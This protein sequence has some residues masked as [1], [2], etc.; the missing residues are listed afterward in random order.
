MKNKTS[1]KKGTIYA[2]LASFVFFSCSFSP[3]ATAATGRNTEEIKPTV[4]EVFVPGAAALIGKKKIKIALLLDTSNSMDG[5]IEQAKS[6]LWKIVNELALAKCENEKPE[7]EIA[8]YEYGNDRLPSSEGYIRQVSMFTNDLD[9]ISEKLFSLTTKGGSEFCGH[10]IQT[11]TQQL[12]WQGDGQNLQ[13]MFIAGNEEFTQG[14]VSYIKSCANAKEKDILINT[15]YCGSFDEGMNTGW[16][17]GAILANGNYMSIEQDRKTVYIDTPYDKEIVSLNDKLNDT[18]ITYGATGHV[19]K[20]NQVKQDANAA[21]YGWSNTTSRVISKTTSVYTNASWDAVD[22]SKSKSF[23]V[24][25]IKEADLPKEMR[26]KTKA[27]KDEY[28]AKKK[29]EREAITAKIG[30][31]N[32]QRAAFIAEKN[33]TQ[34][35]TSSLDASMIKAIREQAEKKKFVFEN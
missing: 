30:E 32:K 16:K 33:K 34:A 26:G 6:Q 1:I 5:L 28:I 4:T 17:N 22:A 23:D 29:A 3:R 15:I 20:A 14:N 35:Q 7:L 24:A 25:K 27:E 12:D 11:A 19:N 8:L 18:Y 31:L 2:T 9:L 21:T 10:V 13:I